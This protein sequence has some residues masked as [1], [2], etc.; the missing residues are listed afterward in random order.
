M[1]RTFFS[2]GGVLHSGVVLGFNEITIYAFVSH[3]LEKKLSLDCS[4]KK[5]IPLLPLVLVVVH[6]FNDA[7]TVVFILTQGL[8]WVQ[9]KRQVT[10]F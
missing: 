8:I 4:I 6:L 3:K 1:G 10:Y 2:H 5:D 9:L 7:K